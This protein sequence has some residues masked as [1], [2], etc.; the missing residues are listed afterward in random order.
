MDV[1]GREGESS[2][3]RCRHVVFARGMKASSGC[4]RTEGRVRV[5]RKEHEAPE[6]QSGRD[7]RRR[8]TASL[9]PLAATAYQLRAE[10][11]GRGQAR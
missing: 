4:D 6:S 1:C 8:L 3:R 2:G 5:G 11:G 7:R 10:A 9:F